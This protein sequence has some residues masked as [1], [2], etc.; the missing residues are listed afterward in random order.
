VHG[1]KAEKNAVML[2]KA[3]VVNGSAG[4]V[5]AAAGEGS[6]KQKQLLNLQKE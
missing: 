2:T 4:P 5:S 6:P 1:A 3:P